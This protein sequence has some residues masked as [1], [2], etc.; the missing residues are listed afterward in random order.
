MLLILDVSLA[1]L[2]VYVNTV[3]RMRNRESGIK[4]RLYHLPACHISAHGKISLIVETRVE[5]ESL[6][7]RRELIKYYIF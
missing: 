4:Y 3:C 6:Q 1:S 7:S 5:R 2:G